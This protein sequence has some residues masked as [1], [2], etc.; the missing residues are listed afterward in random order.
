M[1]DFISSTY[2]NSEIYTPVDD[3]CKN[4]FPILPIATLYNYFEKKSGACCEKEDELPQC[5]NINHIVLNVICLEERDFFILFYNNLT[6]YFCVNKAQITN[7]SIV[8][9]EQSYVSNNSFVNHFSLYNEVLKCFEENYNVSVNNVNPT[10]IISLQK[11]VYKTQSLASICG[12]QVGL[13]WDQVINTLISSGDI[14][15]SSRNSCAPVIFQINF[16]FYSCIMNVYLNITFQYKVHIRGYSL[17]NRCIIPPVPSSSSSS[18]SDSSSTTSCEPSTSSSSC[19]DSSSSCCDSSNSCC[20]S[21]SSCSHCNHSSSCSCSCSNSSS[22]SCSHYDSDTG[23]YSS[24]SLIG[25]TT[26][27]ETSSVDKT[28]GD[29]TFYGYTYKN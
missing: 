14:E 5:C 12:T 19:C 7:N 27:I 22:T 8:F 29:R 25:D 24:E 11:E 1:T 23:S 18:S 4:H 20:D 17:K 10:K 3:F 13:S 28:L 6:K 16:R 9:S 21:S 26:F 2:N 15:H